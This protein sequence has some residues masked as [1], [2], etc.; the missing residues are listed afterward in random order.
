MASVKKSC[1][2]DAKK[3]EDALK[4]LFPNKKGINDRT[5]EE[6]IKAQE[7]LDHHTKNPSTDDKKS[8]DQSQ[9]EAPLPWVDD[10]KWP[11]A[12]PQQGQNPTEPQPEPPKAN[13]TNG[14]DEK[15]KANGRK[16]IIDK[17]SSHFGGDVILINDFL[18]TSLPGYELQPDID[19]L[20]E[21]SAAH[22]RDIYAKV[23]ALTS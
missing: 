9:T 16:L 13:G 8:S 3:V 21:F 6:L 1:G 12:K 10:S 23:K 15:T 17:L 20:V 2:N 14:N 4:S 7:I 22:L 19:N 5:L 11:D 18:R